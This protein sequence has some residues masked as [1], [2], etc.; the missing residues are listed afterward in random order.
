MSADS[1]SKDRWH[2]STRA[3]GS[4]SE[5]RQLALS[6]C[7][8]RSMERPGASRLQLIHAVRASFAH[9]LVSN[10]RSVPAVVTRVGD[11]GPHEGHRLL[12]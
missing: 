10:L 8:R 1:H 9:G 7:P 11:A 4:R 3:I 2:D 5:A 12:P 6:P